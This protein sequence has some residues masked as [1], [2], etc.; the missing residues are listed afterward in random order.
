MNLKAWPGYTIAYIFESAGSYASCIA[1][2][3]FMC[4]LVG[5]CWILKSMGKDITNDLLEFN[6]NKLANADETE[7]LRDFCDI[8]KRLSDAKQF[9]EAFFNYELLS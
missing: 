7:L 6:L 4:V 8:S 5:S 3:P 9:S 2:V 1:A